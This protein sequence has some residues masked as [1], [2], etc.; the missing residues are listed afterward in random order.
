MK[1]ESDTKKSED[2]RCV[3]TS[4]EETSPPISP[5][6]LEFYDGDTD[7][8]LYTKLDSGYPVDRLIDT[9]LAS[10]MDTS[11]VCKVQP[12][13]VSQN[14]VFLIDLDQ[15]HFNDLKA[16]DL[17]SWKTTGTKRS[18]FRFTQ[19]QAV[20]YASGKLQYSSKGS[21]NFLLTRR[22]YVHRTYNRFHRIISD[23]TGVFLCKATPCTCITCKPNTV[24]HCYS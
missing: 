7:L 11:R 20:Q 17:G 1:F 19:G 10:E 13:G 4:D 6:V 23:I 8:P 2:T 14:A 24:D 12:L 21:N 15:V 5:I 16:D 3:E 9:L 22:Y 18:N